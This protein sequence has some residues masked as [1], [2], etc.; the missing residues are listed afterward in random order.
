MAVSVDG[1]A[2]STRRDFGV[3]EGQ[4]VYIFAFDFLSGVARKN[5]VGCVRAFRAAFPSGSEAVGLVV[6]VMRPAADSIEWQEFLHEAQMDPRV[7]VIDRT[8]DRREV[9]DLYR[10]CD[11]FVSLHPSEGFGRGLAEAMLLGRAVVA[12]GYSG[13]MDFTSSDTAGLVDFVMRDVGDG[14]YTFGHG[15]RWANPDIDHAAWCIRKVAADRDCR[16]RIAATYSPAVVGGRYAN[17]GY[18]NLGD[19]ADGSTCERQVGARRE[20][21]GNFST[22]TA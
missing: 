16:E 10:A 4:F 13:N 9:L 17:T 2:G 21:T 11:C 19:G 15:R 6:K 20:R 22:V 5:P 3:S 8:L 12:T 1:T 14:E 7:T 18:W